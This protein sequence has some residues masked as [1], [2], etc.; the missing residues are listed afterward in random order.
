LRLRIPVAESS[1]PRR[2]EISSDAGQ[3]QQVTTGSQQEQTANV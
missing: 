1:K 3:P 2:V